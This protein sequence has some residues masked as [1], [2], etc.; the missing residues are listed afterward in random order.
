[1]RILLKSIYRAC[2]IGRNT[3]FEPVTEIARGMFTVF[4]HSFRKPITIEY[5]EQ[6]ADLAPRFKGRLGLLVNEDGSD[7]CIAC[8]MCAKVCPC[9]DLIQIEGKKIETPEGK[10]KKIPEKYTIDIGRC[11]FCGNCTE[12]C[13][14]NCLVFTDDFEL[15]RFSREACVYDKD[16]LTIPS[17][18]SYKVKK[19]LGL[20]S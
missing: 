19:K 6:P 5:P 20:E 10:T 9:G 14:V 16:M 1:M 18:E 15:T 2:D 3:F 8:G 13:P 12:V 17:E 11:I 4:I 7:L